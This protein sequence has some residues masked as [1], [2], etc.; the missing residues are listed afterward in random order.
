VWFLF[1]SALLPAL[2]TFPC[3]SA[4]FSEMLTAPPATRQ[5]AGL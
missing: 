3:F 4:W 5:R 2:L 1:H